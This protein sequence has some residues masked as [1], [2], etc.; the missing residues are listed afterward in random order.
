MDNKS[1]LILV[2]VLLLSI[3]TIIAYTSYDS[4]SLGELSRETQHVTNDLSEEIIN[5]NK[6]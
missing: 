2:F 5:D 4:Q 6:S 1:F 3:L